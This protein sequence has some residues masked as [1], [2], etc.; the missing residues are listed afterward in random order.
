[1]GSDAV[2]STIVL[3][4]NVALGFSGTGA[5]TICSDNGVSNLAPYTGA[6]TKDS[7]FG[8]STIGVLMLVSTQT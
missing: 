2:V 4:L 8:V 1:M 5:W 7:L 3:I 6:S